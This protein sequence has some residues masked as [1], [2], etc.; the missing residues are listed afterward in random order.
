V[1]GGLWAHEIAFV[2][3]R[4]LILQPSERS[5][6]LHSFICAEDV[7]RPSFVGVLELGFRGGGGGCTN[8]VVV[9]TPQLL[10]LA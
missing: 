5:S 1:A 3:G 2:T 8:V 7:L 10:L 9:S 6:P 4:F